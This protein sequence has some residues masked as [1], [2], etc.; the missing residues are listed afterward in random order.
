MSLRT[1]LV[2]AT[3][4]A[5]VCG[6]IVVDTLTYSLVTRS[7][8]D[9]V[10]AALQR[11]HT[12]TEQLAASGD[13]D[14]WVLIP[15]VAPGLFVAI[16]GGDG[17]PLFTVPAVSPGEVPV[18]ADVTTINLETRQQTIR[19][20][21]GEEM[22]LLIDTEMDGKILVVGNPLHEVTES[23][24]AL[25]GVLLAASGVAVVAV[26]V[27]AQWLIRIGLRPLRAV[28]S[29]AAAIND[30]A[31]PDQRV[32]G[33]DEPTEVGSLART[34]NAMLD[35]LDQARQERERTVAELRESEARMRQFIADASHELRTPVAATAAYAELFESGARDRPADLER[36]MSGIRIE[37]ARMAQLVSDLTLLAQLDEHRPLAS[38]EVD[39]TELV[40]QAVD[41]AR[42][43]KPDRKFTI[44]VTDVVRIKGDPTRLRQVVDNIIANVL[45]HTP[46]E[47]S[48]NIALVL[49][50]ADAQLTISDTGPGVADD[51]LDRLSDRFYRADSARTRATGGSGLGIAIAAAIVESHNG[52]IVLTHNQPHGLTVRIRLPKE[53]STTAAP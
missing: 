23:E 34:L 50:N 6:L 35:R 10:D 21:N 8:L 38:E 12:P 36:S 45:T 11:A 28:E 46:T 22:R 53:H 14:T 42:I 19:A 48:C 15:E 20:S 2:V 27:L 33:A 18:T 29:S 30:A 4:V 1:R 39:M 32:A 7:Q 49:D 51:Q 37:T 40:L 43:L 3:G 5:F 16:I 24:R 52:S 25:L 9:Q 13:P 44:D 47:A 26:L 41:A 17:T 31:L